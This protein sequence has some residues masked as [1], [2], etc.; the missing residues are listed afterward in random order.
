MSIELKT[1][2]V[3]GTDY[4]R[5]MH[6]QA[7]PATTAIAAGVIL[8][9]I[10]LATITLTFIRQKLRLSGGDFIKSFID[11]LVPFIGGGSIQMRHKYERWFFGV[12]HFAAFFIVAVF[13]GDIVDSVIRIL[14]SK[15][16][17]Y[18]ELAQ[19]NTSIFINEALKL[20][21]NEIYGMLRYVKN[22]A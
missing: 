5:G 22:I 7:I 14:N 21:H 13:A 9:F 4:R 15:V 18:R 6:L 20:Q 12:L 16:S 8:L 10:C 2:F 1:F 11:C 19:T 3:Y 17:T